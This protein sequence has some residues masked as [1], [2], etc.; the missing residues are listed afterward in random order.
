[1]K[2]IVPA[3]VDANEILASL[4]L[5]KTRHKNL[6][7][8]IYYFLSRIVTHNDNY[9]LFDKSDGYI[10]I[11]STQM[12]SILGNRYYYQIIDLLINLNDPVIESDGS[13]Y[14][15]K[16]DDLQGYCKGY[17]LTEKYNTGEVMF[18]TLPKGF[19][20]KLKKLLPN[21]LERSIYHSGERN[22]MEIKYG[23]LTE[24]FEQHQLSIDNRVYDYIRNFGNQ[25]LSRVE[26]NNPYQIKIILNRVGQWLYQIDKIN[27][28]QLWKKVSIDNHRLNSNITG[29]K[30]FLRPFILCN[31]KQLIDI[32]I[33]SSQPYIL[34]TIMNDKFFNDTTTGYNLYTI[35][36]ELYYELNGIYT[37]STNDSNT[38]NYYSTISGYTNYSYSS[39]SGSSSLMWCKFYSDEEQ[40]SIT[41]YQQFSFNTDFYTET[42]K[43]HYSQSGVPVP[44]DLSIERED[45]KQS[46][47]F[48]LFDDNINHREK[49]MNIKLF[50]SVYP[51]IDKWICELHHRIGKD[52]FAYLLQR[53]ESYLLLNNVC[54]EFNSKFPMVPVFTIHDSIITY[55]EYSP[56]LTSLILRRLEEI[57]GVSVGIKVKPPQIDPE[58]QIKDIDKEWHK[59]Q[60]INTQKRYEKKSRGVF[61]SNI[62]RGSE[63]LRF[64]AEILN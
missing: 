34:S 3:A 38:I 56:D 18:K 6:K 54:R 28:G 51:G 52:R 26:N 13:W 14:N 21:N 11:S 12:K 1:M 49:N 48:V 45:L 36:P 20:N 9:H 37:N 62:K 22:E 16:S 2:I 64:S 23:F 31:G 25:L 47:M 27:T 44:S 30:R 19:E 60:R 50:K 42:L 10:K 39:I 7:F 43:L 53:T 32:D 58:P 5:T 29:L 4:N 8:K 24:Q 40:K 59:I 55:P 57:T 33:S 17:R 15:P 63:F 41:R 61:S 46:I 35:Y